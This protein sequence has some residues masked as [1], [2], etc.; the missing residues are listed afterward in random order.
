[1]KNVVCI[2]AIALLCVIMMNVVSAEDCVT[3]PGDDVVSD[4][5]VEEGE[6]PD[7]SEATTDEVFKDEAPAEAASGLVCD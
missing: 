4:A 7:E 5:A 2:L 6:V 3:L 1:M